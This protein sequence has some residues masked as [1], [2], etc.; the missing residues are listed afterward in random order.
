MRICILYLTCVSSEEADKIS[1]IL[2][3]KKLIVCAKRFPVESSFLW[4]GKI[5]KAEEVL[6][7][8]DSIEENFERIKKEVAKIHSYK[9]FVLFSTPVNQTTDEVNHWMK[10]ELKK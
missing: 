7:I 3:E 10:K 1:R 5:D 8:M 2:L 9:T 6:L 4:E